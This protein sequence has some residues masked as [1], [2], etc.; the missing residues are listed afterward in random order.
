MYHPVR[1]RMLTASGRS[2]F[3]ML[4]SGAVTFIGR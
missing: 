2:Q 4:F 3:M 1:V